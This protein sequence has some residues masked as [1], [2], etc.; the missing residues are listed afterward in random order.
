MK[1]LKT[2]LIAILLLTITSCTTMTTNDQEEALLSRYYELV[3]HD[4]NAAQQVAQ[5]GAFL[6]YKGF[7]EEYAKTL[8]PDDPSANYWHQAALKVSQ[9]ANAYFNFACWHYQR[10]SNS[11]FYRNAYSNMK[12]SAEKGLY[13]AQVILAIYYRQGIGTNKSQTQSELWLEKAINNNWLKKHPQ[14]ER[15]FKIGKLLGKN[16]KCAPTDEETAIKL[17]KEAA[18]LG[19]KIAKLHIEKNLIPKEMK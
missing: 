9:S 10:A 3:L 1:N 13:H 4:P 16:S 2:Y 5:M 19:N 15:Y 7:F 6:G 17:I 11:R 8:P 14:S 18:D 12:T